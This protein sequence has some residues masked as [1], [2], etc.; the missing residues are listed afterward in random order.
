MTSLRQL[1]SHLAVPLYRNGYALVANT[2]VTAGLGAVYWVVAARFFSAEVVGINAAV[3][4]AMVLIAHLSQM[5]LKNAL[6]R[7]V[8]NAGART[9]KLIGS[10]YLVATLVAAIASVAFLVGQSMWAPDL[11]VLRSSPLAAIG[12]VAATM[13]WTVFVLQDGALT[14]LRRATWILPENAVYGL[15]KIG[16]LFVFTM[17]AP[18]LGIF[19]SATIPLLLLIVPVNVM[20]YRLAVPRHV[21]ATLPSATPVDTRTVARFAAA[22]FFASLASDLTIGLMPMLVLVL[23]GAEA[24]AYFF[25]AWTIAYTLFLVGSN[26]GMSLITEAALDPLKLRSFSRR[27]LLQTVAIV[28]P[29]AVVIAGLAPLLLGIFG[30]DY[31]REGSGVLRLLV[32]AAVPHAVISLRVSTMRS[33]WRMGSL[34]ILQGARAI[35]VIGLSVVLVPMLGING[36]GWAWLITSTIGAGAVLL[37]SLRFLWLPTLLD[38]PVGK[39]ALAIERTSRRGELPGS[40]IED[41][42][43]VAADLRHD[44]DR[45]GLRVLGHV[46][47]GSHLA[48]ATIGSLSTGPEGVLKIA[49]TESASASLVR[50]MDA[51]SALHA[52]P[53]L[54]RFALWVPGL[55]ASGFVG[56]HTFVTQGL[57]DG[58]D[59]KTADL[60]ERDPS[61][62]LITASRAI[63][64]LHYATGS[65]TEL[66]SEEVARLV[67]LRLDTA[68]GDGRLRVGRRQLRALDRVRSELRSAMVG[69]RVPVSWIHGDYW[70]GNVVV[71]PMG[72]LCGI[73]DWDEMQLVGLPSIDIMHLVLTTRALVEDLELGSV[74]LA[75]LDD[76]SLSDAEA[77]VIGQVDPDASD[78]MQWRTL[79]LLTWLHHVTSSA[80]RWNGRSGRWLWT[81]RNVDE[82]LGAL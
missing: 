51:L 36:V 60:T 72:D 10:S 6:N 29:V 59:G 78:R 56:D 32:M 70:L 12:F 11:T 17:S 79:V 48:V 75:A 80:H 61:A 71:G 82:V 35:L 50:E 28:V 62:L 27:V 69:K 39:W 34:A 25:L 45:P 22:D 73:I 74:V 9:G 31:A 21:E 67:D 4:S 57:V 1:S 55:L 8:P 49:R 14:G 77:E 37:T 18:T 16:L 19:A 5:N 54:K 44:L 47:S 64:E 68:L 46:A 26:T 2:V 66:G 53:R 24:T 15:A 63:A 81:E 3:L 40:T 38:G 30:P 65:R 76:G 58:S 41:L 52:D 23:V 13:G 20:I 42:E 33:E 7:F 43:S